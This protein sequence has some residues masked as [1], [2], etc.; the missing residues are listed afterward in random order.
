MLRKSSL[1]VALILSMLVL[2]SCNLPSRQAAQSA[3][4][5]SITVILPEISPTPVRLCDNQYFPND[6]GNTWEY[7][8]SNTAIGAYDRKDI[9]TSSSNTAFT[10]ET[11]LSTVTYPVNYDCSSAGLA[12][13]DPIQQYVGALLNSPDA[14]VNV[15]LTS[16][17][18]I[19]LPAK[20][21]PGDAWQQTADWEASSQD[22]NLKGRFAFNYTAVGY[23]SVTVPFGT[24]NAL[25][26]DATIRIE[27][28]GFRILAG[29]YTTTTWM[30]PEVGIIKSEGTSHIP[31]VDF[32]DGMQLTSYIP[33]P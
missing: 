27:V 24:F 21:V 3:T 16:I 10:L 31:G 13:A 20:I 7:S 8:G 23:E 28:S 15:E 14:P 19:S 1:I 25:R 32:T 29:T 11:T 33:A 17:S 12:A 18:G 2:S 4:P 30:V 9:V 22:F 6:T 26:V 5:T